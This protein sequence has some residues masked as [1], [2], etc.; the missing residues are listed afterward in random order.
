MHVGAAERLVVYDSSPGPSDLVGIGQFVPAE[1][2][3]A[4]GRVSLAGACISCVLA[5]TQSARCVDA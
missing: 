1:R 3:G 4:D 5:D 2:V